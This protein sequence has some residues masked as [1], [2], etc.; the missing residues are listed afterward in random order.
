MNFWLFFSKILVTKSEVI[1]QGFPNE[2][3]YHFVCNLISKFRRIDSPFL[4]QK[5]AHITIARFQ[6]DQD[7]EHIIKKLFDFADSW[8]RIENVSPSKNIGNI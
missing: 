2:V 5:L 7:D 4:D 3:Y 6:R 1:L 8:E